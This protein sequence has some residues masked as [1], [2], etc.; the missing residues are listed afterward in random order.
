MTGAASISW[1]CGSERKRGGLGSPVQQ[2]DVANSAVAATMS[3]D[4]MRIMGSDAVGWSGTAGV[5]GKMGRRNL[6]PAQA[7]K[8][9]KDVIWKG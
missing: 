2:Q 1:K 9:A 8:R 6:N 4:R 3:A 7:G 5:L